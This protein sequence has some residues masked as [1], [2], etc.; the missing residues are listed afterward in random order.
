MQIE[1]WLIAL[2][3]SYAVRAGI[4]KVLEYERTGEEKG[5]LINISGHGFLD[6]P[7]Y[8]EKLML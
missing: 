1:G 4:D 5:I 3:S 7:A 2:E 8:K 6:T